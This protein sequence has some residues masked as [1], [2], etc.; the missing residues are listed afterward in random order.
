MH[1]FATKEGETGAA[2]SCPVQPGD[3]LTAERRKKRWR[4]TK[5]LAICMSC[6]IEPYL[7]LTLLLTFLVLSQYIN[8]FIVWVGFLENWSIMI[9]YALFR[10]IPHLLWSLHDPQILNSHSVGFGVQFNHQQSLSCVFFG[11]T[12]PLFPRAEGVRC[13]GWG[14]QG[15]LG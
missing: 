15:S 6:W 5:S 10:M 9:N 1:H 11:D 14:M 12:S 8:P 7:K 3:K 4:E 13:M 2:G